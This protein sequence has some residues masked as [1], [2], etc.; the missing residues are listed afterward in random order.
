MRSLRHLHY[1][2]LLSMVVAIHGNKFRLGTYYQSGMV[3][4]SGGASM[5]GWG[6]PS[7]DI[8]V[9]VIQG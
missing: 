3:L 8:Q 7:A 2:L 1:F 6:G 5:W 9:S 4:Q